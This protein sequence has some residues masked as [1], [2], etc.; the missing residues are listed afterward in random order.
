MSPT[1]TSYQAIRDLLGV[2][3]KAGV[4]APVVDVRWHDV[5]EDEAEAIVRAFPDNRWQAASSG[6]SEWLSTGSMTVFLAKP[7]AKP[8]ARAQAVLAAAKAVTKT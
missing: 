2:A 4:P 1:E 3:E 6:G 7:E 5:T 8:A